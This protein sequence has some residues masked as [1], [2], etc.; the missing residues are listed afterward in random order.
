MVCKVL[1]RDIA[2]GCMVTSCCTRPYLW[3]P[4]GRTRCRICASQNSL[5]RVL[6]NTKPIKRYLRYVLIS[7]RVAYRCEKWQKGAF[8]EKTLDLSHSRP[9]DV[10]WYTVGRAYVH[11]DPIETHFAF[12]MLYPLIILY[13]FC[14]HTAYSVRISKTREV[15]KC[16]KSD[17]WECWYGVVQDVVCHLSRTFGVVFWIT[18]ISRCDFFHFCHRQPTNA[19]HN[20]P[21]LGNPPDLMISITPFIY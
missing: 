11:Y 19:M 4:R 2:E 14:H 5:I 20:A 21:K 8:V 17:A 1:K 15:L 3:G 12:M 13:N 7:K 10:G 18:T 16:V 6:D 9:L